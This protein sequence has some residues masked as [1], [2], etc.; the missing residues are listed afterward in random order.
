MGTDSAHHRHV[1]Q[2]PH[3]L[4]HIFAILNCFLGSLMWIKMQPLA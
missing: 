2:N 4:E 3:I 1:V